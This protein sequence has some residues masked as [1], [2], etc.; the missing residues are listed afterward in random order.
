MVEGKQQ[1]ARK[2]EKLNAK[3]GREGNKMERS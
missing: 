2:N 3:E 1:H